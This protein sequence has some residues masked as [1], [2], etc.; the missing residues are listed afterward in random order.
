MEKAYTKPVEQIIQELQTDSEKGLTSQ[1][2]ES[3]LKKYGPNVL[4]EEKGKSVLQIFFSQF[5]SFLI[6]ILLAASI[7]SLVLGETLDATLILAI[8]ILNGIVGF[9]QEYRVEKTI[10]SLKKLV[11]VNANVYRDGI[12]HQI[13][14]SNL[15]PGDLIVLEEGQ[16]IPADIRLTQVF[17]LATNEASLTGESTPVSKDL[18]ILPEDTILADRKNMGFSGT[19][20]AAGKGIGVVMSTGMNTE[21]GRIATLVSKEE[22][23][24]TPLQIKLNNL[25]K[26]IGRIVLVIAAI[27]GIEQFLFGQNV[28]NALISAIALAVAAIPEGLPAVVTI[29]LALGT[30]RLLKQKSLIRHLAAAETLGS[31]D[32]ICA[33]KTGTLT[34]GV[35][36]VTEIYGDNREKILT[37]GLL[38]SNARVSGDSPR[39][40]AGQIIGDTTEAALIQATI[41]A[42][43]DQQT[44]LKNYPRI[45]EIPFS[46][47][48]KMMS[49]VVKNGQENLIVSK[50]ATEIILEKCS[51]LTEQQKREILEKNDEMAKKALRVLAIAYGSSE[52]EEN[53]T[54]LG[55]VGMIDPA[56]AG[57]KQAI[58]VCQKQAG[59]KVVMITGDHLLTAEAIAKEIGITGKSITGVDLDKLSDE[60]FRQ[61][62][63]E[64]AIYARVNP[65][66]KIKIIK[67]LKAHGHQVA[68]T[69]DGVNDAP[70]LKAADVGVAMG[71]TGTDVAKEASDIILLDDH[72]QTI[73][74]AVKEGRAIFDNIRKFVN[75]LLSSNLMEVMVISTAVLLGGGH[76]PLLPVHLLWINLVTD[77]LPAVALGVDPPRTNIMSI[78]PQKFREEIVGGKFLGPLILV[79]ILLTIAILAIFFIYQRDPIYEQTMVFTSIVFYEMLRIVAIRSEYKLPFFS[80]IYLVLAIAGSLALQ[81]IILYLPLSFAGVTL[82]E[83]FKVTPLHLQD[84]VL[85]L[86]T[87]IFLLFFMR[88]LV[89]TPIFNLFRS[90]T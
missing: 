46:S 58:E 50:G 75:Y 56:R 26:L 86:G 85:L 6:L 11:T 49:V 32:V 48:R 63:E 59:I 17:N 84:W 43:L 69:G 54:F 9:I 31:T 53:L 79:S 42:G 77:G 15:V 37:Y 39:G 14:S 44:L 28:L 70:A 45:S 76:L 40:E 4:K 38:A 22:E 24:L 51:N 82:Q 62:V 5:T 78:P 90:Q 30:R 88:I 21:I 18:K 71:I 41:D 25:G 47:Q 57:V 27:I 73:V 16:K 74:S 68:M 87:G 65:E 29:S 3:R 72:F 64:I 2:A 60:Q 19:A 7:V 10:E 34:E 52:K 13:P 35:M 12:L 89:I 33:D 67:A 81:L 55:L 36:K 80:N 83:L 61:Q 66:H 8:V 23:K 20:V 1:E